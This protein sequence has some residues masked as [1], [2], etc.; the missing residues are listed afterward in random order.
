MTLTL[1]IDLD[2]TLLDSNMD[3]FIQAYFKKLAGFLERY[4]GPQRLVQELLTGTMQ[5][6]KNE[7][8]DMTLDEVFGNYFYP[9]LGMDRE[10][11]RAEI[12]TFYDEVFPKLKSLTRP[13]PEA[14]KLVDW[15]LEQGWQVVVATNPLFPRKAIDHRLRWA[16]LPPEKYAFTLVT[17]YETSHF[18][19]Q[20]PA[21]YPEILGRLGW[22]ETPILMVGDDPRMDV[23]SAQKAGLPVFWV[24]PRGKAN[25]DFANLPQGTIK[26]FRAW[27]ETADLNSLQM[28]FKT[29]DALI[30]TLLSTPAVLDTIIRG[31]R[32]TEW[33]LRP[34]EGEWSLTEILCHMR[35]VDMEVNLPRMQT[36]MSEE[37]AFIAGQN[38]DPWAEE[39]QYNTQEGLEAFYDFVVARVELVEGLKGLS[40]DDWQRKARHTI[41]GPTNAQELVG[42][43]AEHDRSHLRQVLA[44]LDAIRKTD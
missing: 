13:R 10:K 19:K 24:R 11:L 34:Q 30:A 5:M 31:L 4:V 23:E 22:P 2:D 9:A 20:I 32:L 29:P 6:F 27:I 37:N 21:Y 1:L 36:V 14:V 17:S 3:A 7:H 8:P 39:R 44:T 35:D 18:T 15:A 43:M 42:F 12:D 28:D 26:E 40:P 38:T 25:P 33:T 41:F 16:N